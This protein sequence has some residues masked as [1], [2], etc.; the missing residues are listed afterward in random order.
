MRRLLLVLAV[1]ATAAGSWSA[2]A[3][4]ARFA[5]NEGAGAC[6]SARA[7]RGAFAGADLAKG[8]T[9]F[10]IECSECHSLAD[11]RT[12][13]YGPHLHGVLSRRVGGVEGFRYSSAF[14]GR[15]DVWTADALDR[16]LEDPEWFYP[17]TR[18][19]FGGLVD[20]DERRDLIAFLACETD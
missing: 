2:C 16:Y 10:E 1:S 13:P 5:Q 18:M 3:T 12:R 7:G 11:D 20:A 4:P 9:L 14:E 19:R 6:E 8:R 15:S 17:G